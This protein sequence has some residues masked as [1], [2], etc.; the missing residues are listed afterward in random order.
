MGCGCGEEI[1]A[2]LR[3]VKGLYVVAL[4]QNVDDLDTFRASSPLSALT[5]VVARA[6]TSRAISRHK[7]MHTGVHTSKQPLAQPTSSQNPF[8]PFPPLSSL[9]CAFPTPRAILV[10]DL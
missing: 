2:I 5:R 1:L 7:R 6:S 9:A 4:E 8:P 3:E 10:G